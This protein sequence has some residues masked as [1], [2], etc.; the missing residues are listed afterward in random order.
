[1]AQCAGDSDPHQDVFPA[2][3][4]HRSV[5][6]D[7]SVELQQC[8]RCGGI[9]EIDLS[10]H[11]RVLHRLRERVGVDLGAEGECERRAHRTLDDLVQARGIGPEDFV[12]VGI[13]PEDLFSLRDQG[14]IERPER[15]AVVL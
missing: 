7:Y 1:M 12:A 10:S 3:G 11:D 8:D 13:V 14:R 6:P 5:Q 2:D 15:V 9:V 4:L